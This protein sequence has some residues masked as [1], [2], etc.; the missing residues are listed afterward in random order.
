MTPEIE[1]QLLTT[2]QALQRQSIPDD[3]WSV[4]KIAMYLDLSKKSVT[5][6]ILKSEAFPAPVILPTGG[7]RWVAKEVRAWALKHR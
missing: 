4:E 6:H 1:Q 5:N 7:K 3:L 2:L